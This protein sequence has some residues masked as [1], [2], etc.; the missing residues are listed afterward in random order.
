MAPNTGGE[1]FG[2]ILAEALAGGA[3]V[4][5]SDIPAFDSL[6]GHGEFGAL[7]ESENP[8]E[9]AKVVIDLLRNPEKRGDLATRG[10]AYAQRFNW[11]VVAED[12][13]SI[14]EMSLVG[15]SRVRLSSEN[16]AWNRFL[17]RDTN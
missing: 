1:S 8:Q 11:D 16:R 13:F 3:A 17:G 14:Y 7:F 9:L 15:N 6:L 2:I 5:A 12:I 10:K 4:I